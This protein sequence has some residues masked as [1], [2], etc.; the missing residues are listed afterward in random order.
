VILVRFDE[1]I[2]P[3][4]PAAL[5][6]LVLP[7]DVRVESATSAGEAG[8]ADL[9]WIA[10]FSARG[11]RLLISGDEKMRD[12][13]FERAALDSSGL[14]AVFPPEGRFWQPLKLFGQAAFLIRWFPTIIELARTAE[15][16]E[17]FRLPSNFKDVGVEKVAKLARVPVG[18]QGP[19]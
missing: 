16:G 19:A 3:R 1:N 9:D 15:P 13:P 10:S 18:P 17:H 4:I 2:S 12:R 7:L 6:A 11:G 14:I 5:N 8:A